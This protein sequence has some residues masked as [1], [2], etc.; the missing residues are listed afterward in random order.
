MEIYD[1]ITIA[2][3]VVIGA[4]LWWIA[5]Y[6]EKVKSSKWR[7]CWLAAPSA[8]M[9]LTYIAGFEKLMIPAYLGA[10][11]LIAGMVYTDIHTRRIISV[12]AAILAAVSVPLCLLN[13]SYR[14]ID[15]VKDFNKG[16]DSM[17]AHYV[18]SEHKNI[19]WDD[20][21]SRYL[22]LFEKADKD[23]DKI[24]NE[25]AWNKFC[26]EFNDLHVNY[27][28]DEDNMKSANRQASGNDYGL[29]IVTL[30]D[31]R[32][33]AAQV[34][35]SLK[36][37]GIHEGTEVISWNGE[38]PAE[39]DKKSE[40]YSMAAFAD[41]D[42]RKFFEGW[43][44]AGT[45]G[46][47]AKLCYIDDNGK[48]QTI[49]LPKLDGSY[50]D[51]YNEAYTKVADGMKV[52]HMTLNKL[53]D[54][55]AC[56]RIKFMSF[57]SVSEKEKHQGMKEELRQQILEL[58]EQ[59]IRDMVIDLR[60]NTGGSGTMVKAIAEL[61]APEGE[62]YYVT[63]AYWDKDTK[64]Y[65]KEADGTYKTDHDVIY[66][67]DNIL[68]DEGR[69]VVLVSDHSVSASDHLTHVL[70]E[71]DNVTVMGFTESSGSAQGVSPIKLE[72]GYFSYS[73]S[74]MLNK[75][76]SIFIDCGSDMQSDS[77]LDVKVP[78]DEEAFDAIFVDEKDYLMDKSLELLENTER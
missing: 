19:N 45:G 33:V 9:I 1:I 34:D 35:D 71:L 4:V 74:L 13:G 60:C 51:R 52:G 15:Y 25:I 23:H 40:L 63:D 22:P 77:H 18:L 65:V 53:N 21:Y 7:L 55:T 20:M 62:H 5:N 27:A 75:D 56:L 11:V 24:E 72:S 69:I 70:N 54:T 6:S 66:K 78:F 46:D 8:V 59:G 10:A 50:Y 43:F 37:K 31:G 12:G 73:S 2:A 26:A 61:F 42:N 48:D 14:S 32:T 17:R 57:D 28:S 3:V 49:T 30:C 64:S 38:T 41:E 16:F 58:K 68:G 44:A 47:T 39:A 67:G 36:N 29:V 76:G